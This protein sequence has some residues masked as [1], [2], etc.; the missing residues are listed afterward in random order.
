MF[1]NLIFKDK[2]KVLQKKVLQKKKKKVNYKVVQK[3]RAFHTLPSLLLKNVICI[4]KKEILS[5]F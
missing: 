5:I 3:N 1:W 4:I 2:K